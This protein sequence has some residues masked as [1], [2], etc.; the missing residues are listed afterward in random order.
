[1][2]DENIIGIFDPKY[3]GMFTD[4]GNLV[5]ADMVDRAR[6]EGWDWKRT[7]QELVALG[8]SVPGAEE[9]TDTEVREAVF[10]KLGFHKTEQSFWA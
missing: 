1:M 3:F 2:K 10:Y 5:I 4:K 7:Y 6:S 8:S 9:A